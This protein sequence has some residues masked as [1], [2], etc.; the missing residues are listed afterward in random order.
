MSSTINQAFVDGFRSN[1]YMLAQQ[2]GSRY[3]GAVRVESQKAN[4]EF[5]DRLG[6]TEAQELVTR[7]AD[8]QYQDS[9]HSRRAVSLRDFTWADLIDNA[10]KLR[11]LIDPTSEYSKNAFSSFGRRM[12]RIILEAA[13]GNA[14]S[15]QDG[16][17]AVPLPASQKLLAAADGALGTPTNLNV[18]TL[19]RIKEK[20]G[21]NEIMDVDEELFIAVT[22]RQ[23]TSLLKQTEVTSSDYA[24]V[25]ALVEGRVDTYMGFKF[26]QSNRLVLEAATYDTGTGAVDSGGGTLAAGVARRCLAWAK[27]GLILSIGQD[28]EAKIDPLPTKNYSTQVFARMSLGAV[29]MEEEKVVEVVCNET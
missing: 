23:I 3:R 18:A 4:R 5:Y 27:S 2:K 19:R 9:V 24:N 13:R 22:P 29:R 14:Y 25:K 26:I 17:T 28:M 21:L 20:F 12:D 6:P 7:H 15:G 16:N 11:M 8:T 1:I 10:D